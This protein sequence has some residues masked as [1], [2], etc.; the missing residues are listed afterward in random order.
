[1]TRDRANTYEDSDGAVRKRSKLHELLLDGAPHHCNDVLAAGGHR[2]GARLGELRRKAGL[3]IV[4]FENEY[5][6]W[7]QLIKPEPE[8][9]TLDL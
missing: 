5:G 6:V 2:Y 4:R 7:F 8:Q 9:R 1:M 3:N